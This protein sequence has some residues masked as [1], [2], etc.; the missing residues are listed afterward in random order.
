M[1]ALLNHSK[2]TDKIKYKNDLYTRKIRKD[3]GCSIEPFKIYRQNIMG[4]LLN[5]SLERSGETWS[6]IEV[7]FFVV[8]EEVK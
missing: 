7:S 6:S 1:G 5:H 2:Y 3:Q 4:V 8:S